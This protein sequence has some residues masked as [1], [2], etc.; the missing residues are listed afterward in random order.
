MS[1]WRNSLYQ[2]L[3][4]P[5]GY[6]GYEEGGQLT[7]AVRRKPYCV[8][9]LDEIEK[10]HSDVFDIL[11]QVLDDGRLT[12]AQGRTVS[13]KNTIIIATSNIGA[14]KIQEFVKR[15]KRIGTN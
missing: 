9:L 6:V 8:I 3:L 13:F 7:E 2:D 4:V 12:D 15:E 1:I 14:N 11:L 10:A 5:P